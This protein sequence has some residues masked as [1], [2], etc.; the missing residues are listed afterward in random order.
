MEENKPINHGI[1]TRK[2]QFEKIPKSYDSCHF[3]ILHESRH[4]LCVLH[5]V[6]APQWIKSSKNAMA[7]Y[8]L[9]F[10]MNLF[11][12]KLNKIKIN[13]NKSKAVQIWTYKSSKILWTCLK[14][15]K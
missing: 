13:T 7:H 10:Y 5:E 2:S 3:R 1:K 4:F 8:F 14:S 11:D 6:W 9:H 12:F 15:K